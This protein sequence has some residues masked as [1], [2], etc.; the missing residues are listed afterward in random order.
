LARKKKLVGVGENLIFTVVGDSC[1]NLEHVL[2]FRT[3][4]W[5]TN[6]IAGRQ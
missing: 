3:G 5:A 1:F 4:R 6:I 2:S